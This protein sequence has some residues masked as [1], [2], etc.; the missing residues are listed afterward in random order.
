MLHMDIANIHSVRDSENALWDLCRPSSSIGGGSSWFGKLE[1]TGWIQHVHSVLAAGVRCAAI[2]SQEGVSVLVHCSDGWDRTAQICSLAEILL[3]P[4]CRTFMGFR[5]VI[6]KHWLCF[7]HKF[8]HRNGRGAS[9]GS[10]LD[11]ERSPIFGLFVDCVWCIMQQFPNE[12]Q[13]KENLLLALLDQLTAGKCGT[14]LGNCK[15]EREAKGFAG[16]QS[17]CVSVWDYLAEEW[18]EQE[19][20][21]EAWVGGGTAR[22][23]SSG[24]IVLDGRGGGSFLEEEEERV[25]EL[26]VSCNPKN[27]RLFEARWMR[28]DTSMVPYS[29]PKS[30]F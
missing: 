8:D 9:K 15:K 13:F 14:F 17:G 30:Y 11:E 1:A 22:E 7:G 29:K 28:H 25:G 5:A 16:K 23:G 3:D 10:Q 2:L 24:D 12:F 21:N 4:Y 18:G 26:I 19:F 20:L 6:E 27:I